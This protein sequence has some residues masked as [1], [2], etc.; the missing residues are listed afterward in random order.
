MKREKTSGFYCPI[1]I[2]LSSIFLLFVILPLAFT[3]SYIHQTSLNAF[4][5]EQINSDTHILQMMSQHVEYR[6]EEMNDAQKNLYNNLALMEHFHSNP[7]SFTLLEL[8]QIEAELHKYILEQPFTNSIHL[9][10]NNGQTISTA[11]TRLYTFIRQYRSLFA[12]QDHS[13]V[14]DQYPGGECYWFPSFTMKDINFNKQV[15][16]QNFSVGRIF[17]NT[18]NKL[19]P[20]GYLVQNIDVNFFN[21]CFSNLTDDP[22]LQFLI[23][24]SRGNIIWSP[25]ENWTAMPLQQVVPES[26]ENSLSDS[27]IYKIDGV[28]YYATKKT[29]DYNSWIYYMLTPQSNLESKIAPLKLFSMIIILVCIAVF[30]LGTFSFYQLV[31]KPIKRLVV[32]MHAIE[33]TDDISAVP[34]PLKHSANDEI[35][36]LYKSFTEMQQR[37]RLL[38]K[39][40]TRFHEQKLNQELL[41]LHAQINP[42]FL[43]NTLDAINWMAVSLNAENICRMIQALS[44]IMRYSIG[45]K[46]QSVTF[47]DELEILKDYVY[48]QQCRFNHAFDVEYQIDDCILP[49]PI[50]RL[51]IQPFLENAINHGINNLK[52]HG[53]IVLLMED[54]G[55]CILITVKDNGCGMTQ[56]KIS[57]ILSGKTDSIGIYNINQFLQLKYGP[58]YGIKISSI[59]GQETSVEILYPKMGNLSID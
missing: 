13:N 58:E 17:K 56:E 32:Y 36:I 18:T 16:Q 24:D 31:T 39:Q 9:F 4:R 26:R 57:N 11:K 48:I 46:Y 22:S 6:L 43:Y 53:I 51:I 2:K 52:R 20:I 12:S 37:I 8:A 3:S 27:Q 42:H 14:L 7:D 15:I 44:K 49:R 21:N 5:N 38:L 10:L 23:T 47:K 59:P 25:N 40:K 19:E 28:D 34:Y 45:K 1:F 29:S 35:G 30:V 50:D 41:T 55:S 33:P 54:Q